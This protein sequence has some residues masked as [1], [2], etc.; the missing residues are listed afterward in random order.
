LI[1]TNDHAVAAANS[2]SVSSNGSSSN[3]HTAT[4]GEEAKKDVAVIRVDQSGLN[5]KPLKFVSSD[6]VQVGDAVYAT[7]RA[8]NL[9][10]A[11]PV[12]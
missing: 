8:K 12:L 3:A 6:S 10:A 2:L 1:L 4:L 11:P 5:L 7:A 9:A